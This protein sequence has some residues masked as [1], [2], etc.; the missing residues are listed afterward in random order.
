LIIEFNLLRETEGIGPEK[1]GNLQKQ[2]AK[3]NGKKPRDKYL[4]LTGFCL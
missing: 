3:S 4:Q 2:G 1:S